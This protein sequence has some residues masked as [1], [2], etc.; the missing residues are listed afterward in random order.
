MKRLNGIP[1]L[2]LGT[3][4]LHGADAYNAVRMAIDVGYR[5][6][7][8]AQMYGNE[9]DVGRAVKDCDVDRNELFIVTKVDPGNLQASRFS[10]SVAKSIADLGGPVDLLLIHWP[11]ADRDMNATLDR[12]IDEKSRGSTR[13]V[14]VSNFSPSMLRNAQLHTSGAIV[15]NQVEFHP[16]L[17]QHEILATAHELGVVLEAYSPIARGAALAPQII[18]EIAIRVQRPP[19]EVVLRWIVQQGVIPIPMTTKKQ[20]AV[21]N[22]RALEFELNEEDMNAISSLGTKSGRTVDPGSMQGR[23]NT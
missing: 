21:S 17:A 1:V 6:I 4:P 9:S 14:G 11:P 2:G 18:Q 3:Y 23:W 22:L 5:N 10:K 15:C 12:L 13:A 7:D 20:N 16:L 8:T 19:S